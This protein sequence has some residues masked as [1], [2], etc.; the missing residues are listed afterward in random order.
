MEI[1][2]DRHPSLAA[3]NGYNP[4]ETAFSAIRASRWPS[5]NECKVTRGRKKCSLHQR[6]LYRPWQSRGIP[7]G[8]PLNTFFQGATFA[9]GHPPIASHRGIKFSNPPIFNHL[10]AIS[11]PAPLPAIHHILVGF[12]ILPEDKIHLLRGLF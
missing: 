6:Y 4:H 10:R 9:P 11:N 12:K 1:L 5:D 2:R 7:T 3:G 8:Q